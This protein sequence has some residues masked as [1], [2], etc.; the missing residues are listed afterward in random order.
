MK[1][2]E[3]KLDFVNDKVDILGSNADF[4]FISSG[5]YIIPL[6]VPKKEDINMAEILMATDNIS[7]MSLNE[8]RLIAVKLHK[9][10][11]HASSDNLA[12]LIDSAGIEDAETRN[13]FAEITE[14]CD[15]SLDMSLVFL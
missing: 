14:N 4:L 15:M 1:K 6:N 11:A 13:L 3:V 9:Q 5:H 12:K 8:K 7:K 10:F 2:A